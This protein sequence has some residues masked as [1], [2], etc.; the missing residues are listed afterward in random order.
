MTT[1]LK[2]D[3]ISRFSLLMEQEVIPLLR[4]QNGFQDELTV[5]LRPART[6]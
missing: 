1:L 5:F 6:P 4:R 2:P 3:S